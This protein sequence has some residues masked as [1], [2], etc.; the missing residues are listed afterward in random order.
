LGGPL[1][2][3]SGEA[4]SI[5]SMTIEPEISFTIP[6]EYGKEFLKKNGITWKKQR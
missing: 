2:N 6:I 4:I 5:N 3:L 1:I